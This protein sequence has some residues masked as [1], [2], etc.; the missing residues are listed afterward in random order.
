MTAQSPRLIRLAGLG[1]LVVVSLVLATCFGRGPKRPSREEVTPLLQ[2]EAQLMKA[3]G[4]KLDPVLRVKAT[5]TLQALEVS[6]QPANPDRPWL[7]TIRFHIR[8]E[9]K[10]V[11]GS[12]Q[13]DEFDRRYDYNWVASLKRWVIQPAA[14]R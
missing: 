10:D 3:T 7:G 14:A 11:D 8:S 2:Q 12:V 1:L 13:V 5:W 9:T 4:E 6:E